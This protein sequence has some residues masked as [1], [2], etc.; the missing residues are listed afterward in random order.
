VA[1]DQILLMEE[2]AEAAEVLE[3]LIAPLYQDAIQLVL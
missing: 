1:E 2:A 3:N